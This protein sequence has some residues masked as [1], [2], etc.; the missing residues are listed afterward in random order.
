MRCQICCLDAHTI[1][2]TYEKR[3]SIFQDGG[4]KVCNPC[5]ISLVSSDYE[6]LDG[7]IGQKLKRKEDEK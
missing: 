7:K 4:I 3:Y 5:F 6:T 2:E 1:V